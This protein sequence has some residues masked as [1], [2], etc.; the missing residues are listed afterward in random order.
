MTPSILARSIRG[1]EWV[2]AGEIETR[3]GRVIEAVGHREVRFAPSAVP[4]ADDLRLATADD[5]LL[6]VGEIDGIGRARASLEHLA[7]TAARLPWQGALALLR[8][9]RPDAAPAAFTISASFLGKR[10]YSRYEVEDRVAEGL[11]EPLS[12][13]YRATREA[14]IP[15]ELA[16]RLHIVGERAT[17]ALRI[18]ERPLHRRPYKQRSHPGTLH[19][20]LA[21]ALAMLAGLQPGAR[22]LDP[23]MGAGTIPIECKLLAP[24]AVVLGTDIDAARVADAAINAAAAGVVLGA[25]VADA[26]A[27]PF[28]RGAVDR[29][30]SNVPWNVAVD[31]RGRLSRRPSARDAEI[32]RVLA[33][34]GRAVLLVP[35]E[36]ALAL[37][38]ESRHRLR[39]HLSAGLSVF[40]QHPRLCVLTRPEDG[41]GAIIDAEAPFGPALARNL[42]LLGTL[43]TDGP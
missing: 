41:A 43:A 4:A 11:R 21:G 27:L 8:R 6:T 23:F 5:V 12:L 22:V 30:V 15:S 34:G 3:F 19:P 17:V 14:A 32:A 42:A 9:L 1:V 39:L 25:A 10:N 20:P 2:L 31:L 28:A 37:R 7:R 16:L 29:V 18:F 40:G 35:P 33:P 24:S 38:Q 36:E 26:A 13:A